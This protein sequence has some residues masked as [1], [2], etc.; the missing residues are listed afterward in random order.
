MIPDIKIEGDKAVIQNLD[1]L[2]RNGANLSPAFSQI[3]S[4]MLKSHELNFK[5]NGDRFGTKWPERK[6]EYDHDILYDTGKLSR[7]FK[8]ASSAKSAEVTNTVSYA[9]YHQ[10][11]TRKLPI[12]NL[13]GLAGDGGKIDINS[14]IQIL[15]KHLELGET[16]NV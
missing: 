2:N 8:S 16:Q 4:E 11:G 6:R 13:I 3:A 12:R 14:A 5:Q 7:G 9:K 10:L 1:R 15:R